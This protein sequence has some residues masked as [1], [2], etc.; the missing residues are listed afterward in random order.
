MFGER[1]EQAR[2][3]WSNQIV[4][5]SPFLAGSH[6]DLLGVPEVRPDLTLGA[7]RLECYPILNFSTAARLG[8]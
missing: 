8:H 2:L 6:F 7:I 3:A 5:G 1:S 4:D